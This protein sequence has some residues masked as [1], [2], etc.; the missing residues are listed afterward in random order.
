MCL[1]QL[2][3]SAFQ[4]AWLP[5]VGEAMV[6]D[7]IEQRPFESLEALPDKVDGLGSGTLEAIREFLKAVT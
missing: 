7:I 4:L 5:G 2:E 1:D 6:Q 3:A